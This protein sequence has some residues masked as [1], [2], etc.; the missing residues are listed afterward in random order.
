MIW[1]GEKSRGKL[2]TPGWEGCGLDVLEQ[3]DPTI[4][5]QMSLDFFADNVKELLS[6]D[7]YH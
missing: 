1:I 5:E 2:L 7:L 4:G 6:T 3:S